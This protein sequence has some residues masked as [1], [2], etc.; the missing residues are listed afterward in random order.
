MTHAE[1][2]NFV[3]TLNRAYDAFIR[4]KKRADKV[5]MALSLYVAM[6][7]LLTE[8]SKKEGDRIFSELRTGGDSSRVF[9]LIRVISEDENI[10]YAQRKLAGVIHTPVVRLE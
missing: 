8:K 10:I 3:E 6:S 2:Y 1:H 5:E 7:G 9:D 4:E